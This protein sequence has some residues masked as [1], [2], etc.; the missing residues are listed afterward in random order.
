MRA[1]TDTDRHTDT[2][3]TQTHKHAHTHRNTQTYKAHRH[4]NAHTKHTH[5]TCDSSE[6]NEKT[7]LNF[8]P[9][10][11]PSRSDFLQRPVAREGLSA[12]FEKKSLP[13]KLETSLARFAR[14]KTEAKH[15]HWLHARESTVALLLATGGNKHFAR[16]PTAGNP[17]RPALHFSP[18]GDKDIL[19]PPPRLA[20]EC[21]NRTSLQ[22][23]CRPGRLL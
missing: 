13:A 12:T 2:Q 10:D 14:N 21:N 23:G 9:Y 20:D 18:A 3:D 22:A 5:T 7:S 19:V 15:N 16:F 1:H 11:D 17:T 6:K 4:K 8:S